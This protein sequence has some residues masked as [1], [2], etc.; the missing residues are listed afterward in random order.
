VGDKT[1]L[2]SLFLTVL[3]FIVSLAVN[4]FA[5]E[6]DKFFI[7]GQHPVYVPDE[8]YNISSGNEPL[9]Q[10]YFG[11]ETGCLMEIRDD[12]IIRNSEIKL[13]LIADTDR[14]SRY[15]T[16]DRHLVFFRKSF[17]ARNKMTIVIQS[18]NLTT[19]EMNL[20]RYFNISTGKTEKSNGN[21]FGSKFSADGKNLFCFLCKNNTLTDYLNID[22]KQESF[23][24][25]KEF[26]HFNGDGF[27]HRIAISPDN[28][29]CALVFKLINRSNNTP[30]LVIKGFGTEDGKNKF[31]L[32][33]PGF[34]YLS[35]S[36]SEKYYSEICWSPDSKSLLY[37]KYADTGDWGVFNLDISKSKENQIFSYKLKNDSYTPGFD[38]TEK[39]ILITLPGVGLF[40]QAADKQAFV[41]IDLPESILSHRKGRISPDGNKIMFFG[42]KKEET[43]KA[44]LGFYIFVKDL[45]TGILHQEKLDSACSFESYQATWIYPDRPGFLGN[46]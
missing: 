15:I 44:G 40:Y 26:K 23:D 5:E 22:V 24:L 46:K 34:L 12:K 38:W 21:Y 19:L 8:Q 2:Y 25:P 33:E 18:Y 13:E 43:S 17:P 35:G 36:I 16:P 7:I 45:K 10:R 29:I 31:S 11:D 9:F 27:F 30:Y 3:L 37:I 32:N 42:I 41:K 14:N 1:K 28:R 6:N 39:G 4:V 20:N